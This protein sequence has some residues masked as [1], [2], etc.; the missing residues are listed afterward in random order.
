MKQS[1]R[2]KIEKLIV[3]QGQL[4]DKI[5]QVN[6]DPPLIKLLHAKNEKRD[7]GLKEGKCM[8]KCKEKGRKKNNRVRIWASNVARDINM[9]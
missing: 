5:S 2:K 4:R 8:L 1:K 9:M 6:K 3:D 7:I